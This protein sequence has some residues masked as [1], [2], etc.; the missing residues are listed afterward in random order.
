MPVIIPQNR[1]ASVFNNTVATYKYYWLL[2]ILDILV[3]EGKTTVPFTEIITQMIANA[4]YPVHYFKLS[5]GQ[6]DSLYNQIIKIQQ[7]TQL[8]IDASK[9]EIQKTLMNQTGETA[10]KKELRLFSL[11]VPYRFLSPW[12]RFNSDSYVILKSQEFENQ[13][14]YAIHGYAHDRYIVINPEWTDYLRKNYSM[15]KDFCYWNLSVF[16]SKRNPN[17]PNIQDKLVKPIERDSLIQQHKYWDS[18][19]DVTGPIYC[20]Y[21]GKSIYKGDYNLDH[22]IP[23][24]FVAHNLLWNLIPADSSINSSKSNRL[25]SL[26]EYLPKYTALQ[27]NALNIMLRDQPRNKLLED[28][29]YLDRHLNLGE[30]NALSNVDFMNVYRKALTPLVQTAENMGFEIWKKYGS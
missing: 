27:N 15:L 6:S 30:L 22:F 2:S 25:P 23:W 13:C 4:W 8:P 1:I 11:N 20:I 7:I 12:I 9:S 14:L 29:V 26:E 21:T 19:I 24:S 5:F 17:V 3:K 18:I 16:L 28:F 10:I